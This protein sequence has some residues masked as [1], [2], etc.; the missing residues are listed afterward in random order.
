MS[1]A[2]HKR[3]KIRRVCR[4]CGARLVNKPE[5]GVVCPKCGWTRKNTF[6]DTKEVDDGE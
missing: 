1:N 2:L 4:K 5:Y 6:V 3:V